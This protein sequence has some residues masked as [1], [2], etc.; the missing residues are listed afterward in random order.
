MNEKFDEKQLDL[1]V[2]SWLKVQDWCNANIGD[3]ECRTFVRLMPHNPYRWT[4]FVYNADHGKLVLCSGDH[5]RW[6]ANASDWKNGMRTDL[7]DYYANK[8]DGGCHIRAGKEKYERSE[9]ID[10]TI[11]FLRNWENIKNEWVSF[12]NRA[13]FLKDFEA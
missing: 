7:Y 12:A 3:R 2:K 13:N 6:G 9:W 1:A 4:A 11:Y 10:E 8:C 5:S